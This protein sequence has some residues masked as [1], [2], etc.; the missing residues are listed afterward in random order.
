MYE[1][2]NKSID[3]T[4]RIRDM[5]DKLFEY[6]L[7]YATEWE[8]DELE[9]VA[10]DKF[11][12][13]FLCEYAYSLESHNIKVHINH[14]ELVGDINVNMPLLQRLFDN[15]YSNLLK[16]ADR[17]QPITISY[18]D[19]SE[20][21]ILTIVNSIGHEHEKRNSTGIGLKTCSRIM[22]Y[23]EGHFE[24]YNDNSKFSTTIKIPFIR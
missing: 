14:S 7:V 16:Y 20:H 19:D 13:Q 23:H 22:Q 21:I 1:L 2:I 3:K 6:F 8:C 5:A 4:I 9:V 17:E 24:I 12:N 10:A 15:I 18:H 11:F